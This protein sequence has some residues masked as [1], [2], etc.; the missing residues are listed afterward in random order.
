MRTISLQRAPRVRRSAR[1]CGSL[2]RRQRR[3]SISLALHMAQMSVPNGRDAPQHEQAILWLPDELEASSAES[4]FM[5]AVP[6][7]AKFL[8]RDVK[9]KTES[10]TES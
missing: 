5:V 8:V 6:I 10:E 9:S 4:R 2:R 3:H 1:S 7:A